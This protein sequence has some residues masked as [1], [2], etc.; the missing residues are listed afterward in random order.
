MKSG[1]TRILSLPHNV[2]RDLGF[3]KS[4]EL[5]GR[6]VVVDGKLMLEMK[7]MEAVTSG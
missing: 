6:W 1:S 7:K 5:M 3:S 4:D 2:Y